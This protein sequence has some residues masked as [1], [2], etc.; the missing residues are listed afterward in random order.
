MTLVVD[1]IKTDRLLLTALTQAHSAG[2][3]SLWSN[4]EVCRYSGTVTDYD[5]IEIPMPAATSG[6]SD[7][8]IDFWERAAADGWGFRWAILR[9]ANNQFIGHVGFNS[10]GEVSEIA[11]HLHP[12]HW[13][14]GLMS[15]AA[16]AAIA[17][18]RAAAPETVLEAF[19][20]PANLSSARLA[21]RLGFSPTGRVSDGAECFQLRPDAPARKK[22]I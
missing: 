7:K 2:M 12:D 5:R 1:D 4:A 18:A 6:E 17:W 11:Y 20:E 19:I 21:R 8:I 22:A 13:G 9:P 10:L 16:R 15:E 14:E 3:F